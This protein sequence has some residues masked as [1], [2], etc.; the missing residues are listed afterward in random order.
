[1]YEKTFTS[2]PDWLGT[3][4]GFNGFLEYAEA[5]KFVRTLKLKSKS[6]WDR[7]VK[8]GRLPANIPRSPAMT[9]QG[10]GWKSWGEWLGTGRIADNFKKYRPFREARAFARKLNLKS[11]AEWRLFCQGAMP[12]LGQLPADISTVPQNTYAGNGWQSWGDWLGTGRVADQLKQFRS[13]REARAF[14]HKLKLKNQNEWTR[15]CRGVLP[16]LKR[17][18]ADIPKAPQHVYTQ[19]GCKGTSDWL[20]T[21]RIPKTDLETGR[22]KTRV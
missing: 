14:V 10:N 5:E 19:K 3:K 18:P 11:S 6:E 15:Y 1:V 8:S 7:Y 12:N 17:L 2:M 13:F 4:I 20:G 21:D 9:Y 16:N 22:S